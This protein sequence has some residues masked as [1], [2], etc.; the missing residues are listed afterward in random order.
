MRL[1]HGSTVVVKAPRLIRQNRFLDFG[2]GF[3]TASNLS[4]TKQFAQKV[5]ERRGGM[6]IINVYE[7]DEVEAERQLKIKR[8]LNPDG[9]WLDFVA[10]N[11][12]G[13]YSGPKY[14]LIIGPV[15]NDDVYQTVYLYLSGVI[16]KS[17]AL[18]ALKVKQLFDQY[19]FAT[20]KALSLLEFIKTE[21]I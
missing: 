9:K 18:K 11:R 1:Y 21:E 5:A 19:V 8:F 15:A 10:Q 20:D 16:T 4:Q 14:D 13:E 17:Q 3:Y 12:C 6:P 7:I 2:F